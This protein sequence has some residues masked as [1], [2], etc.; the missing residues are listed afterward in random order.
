[1]GWIWAAGRPEAAHGPDIWGPCSKA[2]SKSTFVTEISTFRIKGQSYFF[3]E[4]QQQQQ[5]DCQ[6]T[7]SDI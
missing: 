7:F 1:M 2:K 5:S 6:L 4:Q 3:T